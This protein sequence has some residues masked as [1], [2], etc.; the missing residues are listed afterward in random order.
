MPAKPLRMR[1]GD[2]WRAELAAA[3]FL[4]TDAVSSSSM[5][6]PWAIVWGYAP[7]AR[8]D[9]PSSVLTQPDPVLVVTDEAA[10]LAGAV[11]DLLRE[12]GRRV[13][14][15][16]PSDLSEAGVPGHGGESGSEILLFL[17]VEDDCSDPVEHASQQV[18]ALA[19]LATRAALKHS[20]L[21]VVTC[22]AQQP[23]VGPEPVGPSGGALW[24][25][26]RVLVNE[27]PRLTVRLVDL[28]S[29]VPASERARQIAAE[30]SVAG[31][32]D[33]IVWTPAGAPRLARPPR[34]SP[35]SGGTGGH[36]DLGKPSPRR[37]RLSR[38]GNGAGI[39]G[40]TRPTPSRGAC[41]GPQFPRHDVGDG[42]VAGRGADR[43][44][45]RPD[46]RP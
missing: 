15:V 40:W 8:E 7:A 17:A 29:S 39:G 36:V 38:L 18:T 19:R 31:P 3:G 20:V 28:S 10:G 46:F 6:W 4:S 1:S 32:D 16:C 35:A 23:G 25:L 37:T 27:L 43:R 24:G 42:A 33:E 34:A 21:W 30:L 11:Q 9:I 44:F 13:S 14:I 45:R 2:E 26:A 22:D 41:C 5:A 12:G